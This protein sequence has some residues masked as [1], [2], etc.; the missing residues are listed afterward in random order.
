[1]KRASLIAAVLLCVA[2]TA[3]AAPAKWTADH[4]KSK[5]GFSVQWSGEAFN[6]TFKSW[7]ADIHFDPNDLAHSKVSVSIDLASEFSDFDENDQ[8]LKGTQ[9]FETAKFPTAKFEA[10]KFTHGQGNAYVATGTLTLHGVTRPVT[11]PFTLDIKGN[12]AHV[13][14]KTSLLRPDFA[15]AR[16]EFAGETPIAHAVTATIDLTAT[17]K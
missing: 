2:A 17:R 3:N 11:L 4:A 14:G 8:G 9:G 10:T 7:N 5:V 13:V 6:A 1:M 16:G 15:L 12:T